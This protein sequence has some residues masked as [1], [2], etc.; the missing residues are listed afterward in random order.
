MDSI[1]VSRELR[2][3][4]WPL[5]KDAGFTVVRGR[6]AWRLLDDQTELVDFQSFDSH[7]AEGVGCT[8]YSFSVRLGLHLPDDTASPTLAG[9][10]LPKEYEATFPFT[11]LKR[12]RQPWFHPWGDARTTDRR[13][14][15]FVREDGSNLDE[16]VAD[17]RD[18]IATSGL[19]QLAAYRDPRYA[20]CALFDYARR[21]PPRA[22]DV[23]IEVFPCGAY[24]SPRWHHVIEILAPHIGRDAAADRR[25]GLPTD[26]LDE[27][28]GP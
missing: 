23:D 10:A 20:Y 25:A 16:V 14:V 17:A 7:L 12:L 4:V 27:V 5:L 18:V 15:W 21:W 24:G 26:L 11:A 9:D 8:T 3:V 2:S 6:T 19:R 1:V 22:I 28:L 13:D